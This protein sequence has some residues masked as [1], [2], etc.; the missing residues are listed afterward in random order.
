MRIAVAGG[1]GVVGRHVTSACRERGHHVV[2]VS[3]SHGVDLRTG[4]GLEAALDGVDAIVDVTNAGTTGR[5]AATAFFTAVAGR[6]QTVGAACGVRHLVALSIVGL[7][8][9]EGYGY[10]AAKLRHE[11][12]V[13]D[14]PLPATI[15]R[16]TQF[17]EFA[18]QILDRTR[19]GP[20][21]LMP[22]MRVQPVA[23]ATVGAA[24]ADLATAG[25]VPAEPA[26]PAGPISE[27]AGPEPEDLVAMARAVVRHQGRR[28]VVV[29]LRLP[30]AAGRAMRTGA[31]LPSPGARL[32]GPTFEQW[33]TRTDATT[34]VR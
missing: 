27:L 34:P 30:G 25:P 13:L 18:G 29:P 4:E 28:T 8:R 10:Y 19:R 1:T 9:A 3:R 15:L 5:K 23:A 31:L 26:Q 12:A 24:L 17:H 11:Q 14:G 21:A 6:L 16:A 32:A 7:E 33:L 20:L 2:V 22:T